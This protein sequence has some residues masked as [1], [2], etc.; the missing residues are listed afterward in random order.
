MSLK[1][2]TKRSKIIITAISFIVVLYLLVVGFDALSQIN[3]FKP[4]KK[5]ARDI[6]QS[7]GGGLTQSNKWYCGLE[8]SDCPSVHLIKSN[9]VTLEQAKSLIDSEKTY[10]ENYGYTNIKLGECNDA[11]LGYCFAR[12]TNLSTGLTVNLSVKFDALRVDITRT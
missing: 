5:L 3:R 6:S 12:G 1:K 9:N 10:F 4:Y 7:M 2:P 8:S 11:D